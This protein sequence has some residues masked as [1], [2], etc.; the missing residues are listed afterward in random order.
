MGEGWD[1]GRQ[2]SK[3]PHPDPLLEP[4]MAQER[5]NLTLKYVIFP[6]LSGDEKCT[7]QGR[8]AF[9]RR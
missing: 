1:E 4:Y 8:G 6:L 7:P 9:K 3:A 2:S 5:E